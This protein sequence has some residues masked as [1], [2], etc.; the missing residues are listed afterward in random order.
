LE[1]ERRPYDYWVAG[2]YPVVFERSFQ[3]ENVQV[4]IVLLESNPEYVHISVAV[5]DG[6][7]WAWFPPSFSAIIRRVDGEEA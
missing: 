4:E 1:C 7:L 2:D 5:D 6:G 3:G